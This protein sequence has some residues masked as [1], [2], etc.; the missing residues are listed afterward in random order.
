MSHGQGPGEIYRLYD[1]SYDSEKRQLVLYQHPFLLFYTPNGE[2]IEAKRLPFGFYN[3]QAIPEGYVFMTL[4]GAG[5][6]HLGQFKDYTLFVTD[7]NFKLKYAALPYYFGD[8]RYIGYNYLY[9]NYTFKV[10]QNLVDT[11]YQYTSTTN[12]LDSKFVLDFKDKRLPDKFLRGDTQEFKNAIRNNK[13]YF[14]LGEYL[15]TEGQD[16]FFLMSDFT[17]SK[18]VIYRDKKSKRLTGGTQA[19]YDSEKQIPSMGSPEA[20]FK[21]YFIALHYPSP[22]DSLLSNSSFLSEEDKKIIANTQAD[23]NPLLVFF[24]LKDF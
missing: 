3:F 2:F 12:Q 6:E 8:I 9:N 5:N 16:A 4:D 23:D 20:S 13:Y 15:E 1:V 11:I 24:E 18:T 19:I 21:N 17:G 7:K 10:T 22:S 14:F